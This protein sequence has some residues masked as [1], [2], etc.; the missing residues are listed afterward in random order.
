MAIRKFKIT[1]V[2]HIKFLSDGTGVGGRDL[3]VR[4]KNK[5]EWYIKNTYRKC[6]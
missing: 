5:K 1:R 6:C 2:A 4:E 3:C